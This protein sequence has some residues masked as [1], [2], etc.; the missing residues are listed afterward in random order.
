VD[1]ARRALERAVAMDPADSLAAENLRLCTQKVIRASRRPG[2][3]AR[4]DRA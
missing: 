1:E 2:A 4:D 3:R